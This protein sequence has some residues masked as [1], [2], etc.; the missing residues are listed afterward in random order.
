MN[1]V[2]R[3]LPVTKPGLPRRDDNHLT[4]VFA[5]LLVPV[6]AAEVSATLPHDKTTPWGDFYGRVDARYYRTMDSAALRRLS[7]ATPICTV[8][9]QET[10]RPP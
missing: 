8:R 4:G 6:L 10:A 3:S 2:A 9:T 5:Q 1:Y 7:T